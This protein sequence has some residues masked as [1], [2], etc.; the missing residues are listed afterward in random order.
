[1]KIMKILFDIGVSF[2][3]LLLIIFRLINPDNTDHMIIIQYIGLGIA[4]FD[5]IS[6]SLRSIKHQSFKKFKAALA[7]SIILI[8]TYV[9][10]AILG[11]L[12]I[13]VCLSTPVAMDIITLLT[14]WLS[15]P[16]DLYIFLLNGG[17]K[18][19]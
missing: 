18:N 5:L 8:L 4:L 7:V 17:N 10:I 9:F 19:E 13:I 15:I 14:L 6:K 1:M 3:L 11:C 16:Q 12:K 2:G